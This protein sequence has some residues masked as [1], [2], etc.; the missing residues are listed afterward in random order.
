MVWLVIIIVAVSVFLIVRW[1][2][3]ASRDAIGD[4]RGPGNFDVDVV[5]ESN[6]QDAL[7]SICGGRDED[8]AR[9]EIKALLILEDDNRHDNLAVRVDINGQT[10]GYLARAT[11][12]QY[13]TRL[14]EAGHP[15]LTGRCDAIIVGGWDR[16]KRDR[17]H[18]GVKL[19][20]PAGNDS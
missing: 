9:K 13:R 11:A 15:R 20:L 3:K 4:L 19:D 6:Y 10:I 2:T 18:F 12:R 14:K 7:E 16:G 5:G 17:G 8:G 1:Q